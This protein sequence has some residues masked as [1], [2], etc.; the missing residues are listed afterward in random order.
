LLS[1][2]VPLVKELPERANL[3]VFAHV[4]LEFE[5]GEEPPGLYFSREVIELLSEIGAELDVDAVP[6]L[7]PREIG[8]QGAV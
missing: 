2:L 6:C 8:N 5:H 7:S 4:V 3:R 1:R